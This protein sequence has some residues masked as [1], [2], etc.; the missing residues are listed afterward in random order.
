MRVGIVTIYNSQSAGGFLQAMAM[1]HFLRSQGLNAAFVNNNAYKKSKA[2][3]QCALSIKYLMKGQC[4]KSLWLL[5]TFMA[6]RKVR[7]GYDVALLSSA[8]NVCVFGSDTIWN[9]DQ[10]E[11]C[12]RWEH[13]WGRNISCR[14]VLYG[15]SIGSAKVDSILPL[16]D[17][18]DA[19]KDF[20]AY[21]VRDSMTQELIERAGIDAKVHRVVDPTMLM[22]ASFY[23]QMASPAE[24]SK[25]ILFYYF[26][27]VDDSIMTEIKAFA[28]SKGLSLIC[29]GL[30]I[31][32]CK[33]NLIFEPITMLRYFQSADYIITN[34]FHGNVFSMIFNKNFVNI[35][36]D[37]EKVQD[38][39]KQF[40]LEGR[41]VE[42]A[43][44]LRNVLEKNID[45]SEVNEIMD[46]MRE[47][48]RAYLMDSIAGN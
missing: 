2:F 22:P 30:N 21:G 48:S 20:Y 32:G 37:K 45:Y 3:Y 6:Y 27:L 31:P 35:G 15:A 34:T 40:G 9:L 26:G 23:T 13:Y 8:L 46:T 36:K 1:Y 29:F 28:D 7:K 24:D 42:A 10:Q 44:E 17:H 14:K 18:I 38:L 4:K 47:T 43:F 5:R 25:Y 41:S 12:D 11:F 19:L 16:K 33:K 39:Q